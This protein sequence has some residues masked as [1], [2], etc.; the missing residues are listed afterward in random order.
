MFYLKFITNELFQTFQFELIIEPN[1]Q[2]KKFFGSR[3]SF[4]FIKIETIT[5]HSWQIARK[6]PQ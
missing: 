4:Q 2:N 5:K 3:L 6:Y 1:F